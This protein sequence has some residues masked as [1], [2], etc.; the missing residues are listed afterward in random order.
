[1]AVVQVI[2]MLPDRTTQTMNVLPERVSQ[3][4]KVLPDKLRWYTCYL[5][6]SGD[7]MLPDTQV[8]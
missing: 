8:I 2:N 7:N 4:A 3:M 1:M 5:T 6:D